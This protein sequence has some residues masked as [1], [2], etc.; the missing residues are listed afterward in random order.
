MKSDVQVV[1]ALPFKPAEV[2]RWRRTIWRAFADYGFQPIEI[3]ACRILAGIVAIGTD[4]GL[5]SALTG[6]SEDYVKKVLRRL[7]KDRVLVGRS[8]RAS[9]LTEDEA[10]N[11][12]GACLD[13][14]VASGIFSRFVN[15]KRSA[16]QKARARESFARG[17]RRS[18]VARVIGQIFTPDQKRSNPLYGLPEWKQTKEK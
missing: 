14:G 11:S 13:A 12:L 6:S 1:D 10:T 2:R 18:P 5:L 9:W 17:P 8:L 7:R 15:E 16:A 3:P 4:S